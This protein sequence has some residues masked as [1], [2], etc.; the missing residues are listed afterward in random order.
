M[1]MSAEEHNE[2][3]EYEIVRR[4]K[5]LEMVEAYQGI[6]CWP[7]AEVARRLGLSDS[8][9]CQLIDEG[10]LSILLVRGKRY[11]TNVSIRAYEE[12]AMERKLK[13]GRRCKA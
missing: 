11:V 10:K 9:I 5:E 8:R 2:S 12:G 7:Q 3:P 6:A 4:G 13:H 1:F